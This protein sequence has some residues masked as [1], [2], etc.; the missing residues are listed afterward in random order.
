MQYTLTEFQNNIC[1]VGAVTG[2]LLQT[3]E[4]LADKRIAI[5]KEKVILDIGALNYRINIWY[6]RKVK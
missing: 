5:Q 6:K 1:S 3:P 4:M 2:R